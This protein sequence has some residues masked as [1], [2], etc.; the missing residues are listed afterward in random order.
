MSFRDLQ[1]AQ[2][3]A[4]NDAGIQ[5][6]ID[7]F[8]KYA[9]YL[10]L[11]GEWKN[12]TE[13]KAKIEANRK[14]VKH[15]FDIYDT[16]M[17]HSFRLYQFLVDYGRNEEVFNE[18]HNEKP[19]APGWKGV[20]PYTHEQVSTIIADG[21]KDFQLLDYTPKTYTGKLVPLT[22]VKPLT[23]PAGDD[24]WG[25]RM[26]TKGG[27]DLQIDVPKGLNSLP[28]RTDLYYD[29]TITVI[30][31]DGNDI[32]N[33]SITGLKE[34]EQ[35]AVFDI[36]LPGAGRYTIQLRPAAGGG[37]WFQTLKGLTLVFPNFIAEMGAPSPRVYFYVPRGLKTIALWLQS[38][39]FDGAVPQAV[40]DPDGKQ[41]P[42]ESYDG[43]TLVIV[44]VPAGQDGK[45]WALEGVRTPNA[46][47]RMLNVPNYF[48]FSPETLLVPEDALK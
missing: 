38:G 40:F 6:R 44:K 42:T 30:D 36:P 26:P 1:E 47:I 13:P 3:L 16:N 45:A 29:K 33:K 17:V 48:A 41:A 11:Y 32:W 23:I 18:F 31:A 4:G 46:P 43:G 10:R 8:A 2:K 39:D 35:N 19:D 14:L 21:V 12:T 20:A 28:F 15:L 37:L 22:P 9:Q 7:D 25:T 5:A 24:K 34:Y 27:I